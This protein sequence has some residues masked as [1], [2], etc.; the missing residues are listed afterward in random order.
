MRSDVEEPHLALGLMSAVADD[1]VVA[2]FDFQLLAGAD[3]IACDFDFRLRW[4]RSN[5]SNST[6]REF[7]PAFQSGGKTATPKGGPSRLCFSAGVRPSNSSISFSNHEPI[8]S[9]FINCLSS[10]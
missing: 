8:S 9:G 10:L 5:L 7:N 4:R 1:H 2:E 3:Q 6:N